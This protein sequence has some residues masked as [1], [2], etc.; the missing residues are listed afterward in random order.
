MKVAELIELLQ[1][2]NPEAD[3]HFSYN[4]GDYWRTQ[5]AATVERVDL[6]RVAYSDY[7]NMHKVVSEQECDYDEETGEEVAAEGT[8]VVLLG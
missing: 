5:V 3:V 1:Q 8:E 7:H 6:G 4:F 2:E